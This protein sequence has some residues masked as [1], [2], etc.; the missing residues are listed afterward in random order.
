M[1]PTIA[2]HIMEEGAK[3]GYNGQIKGPDTGIANVYN[4]SNVHERIELWEAMFKALLPN[5]KGRG[6]RL[7]DW[8]MVESYKT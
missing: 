1:R 7:G 8:N 6:G 3:L 2:K 4:S 5:C